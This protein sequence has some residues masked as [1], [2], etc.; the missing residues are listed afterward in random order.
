MVI[1]AQFIKHETL[2][3]LDKIM[4]FYVYNYAVRHAYYNI[5][6]MVNGVSLKLHAVVC[7][8]QKA[9]SKSTLKVM[10]LKCVLINAFGVI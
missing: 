1:A 4:A 7:C 6:E 9:P 3:P 5:L 8:R 2:P 10:C